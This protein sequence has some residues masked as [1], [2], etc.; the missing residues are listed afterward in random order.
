MP[1]IEIT[2][3]NLTE[4]QNICHKLH[5]AGYDG[6]SAGWNCEEEYGRIDLITDTA[7]EE[8]S[9]RIRILL[10]KRVTFHVHERTPALQI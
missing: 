5:K 8:F 3:K 7:P 6:I 1:T 10:G 9:R 2:P 4:Y